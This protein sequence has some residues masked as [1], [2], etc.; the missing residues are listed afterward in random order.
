[1]GDNCTNH[2]IGKNGNTMGS[3]T[4]EEAVAYVSTDKEVV[5]LKNYTSPD[6]KYHVD[7][8]VGSMGDNC[9]TYFYTSK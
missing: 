6:G 5:T 7:N 1:M 4:V 3:K 8:F 9:T 2:F